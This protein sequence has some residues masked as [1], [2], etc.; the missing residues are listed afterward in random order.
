MPV[1]DLNGI[2]ICDRN[3]LGLN[4]YYVPILLVCLI[5][6]QVPSTASALVHQP[7][8]RKRRR[9]RS[10]DLSEA[11]IGDIWEEIV[12]DWYGKELN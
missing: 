7:K 6:S 11:R 3:M 10:R 8:I 2:G 1:D 4:P 12:K 9:K 5:Y